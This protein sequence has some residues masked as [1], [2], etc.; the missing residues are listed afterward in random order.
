MSICAR[1]PFWPE[2]F[3]NLALLFWNQILIWFSFSPS[4]SARFLRRS[5]VKYLFSSNSRFS[6]LSWS[7][8]K[9]VLGLF[10]P[11]EPAVEQLPSPTRAFS[12]F[13]IF[14]DRGPGI[15]KNKYL[16][17]QL[18]NPLKSYPTSLADIYGYTKQQRCL[19]AFWWWVYG[20]CHKTISTLFGIMETRPINTLHTS[21]SI[22]PLFSGN[23]L[24]IFPTEQKELSL[25]FLGESTNILQS[26]NGKR[27]EINYNFEPSYVELLFGFS[28]E[29]LWQSL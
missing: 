22:I 17:E 21:V 16:F 12:A 24:W 25:A 29:R 14:R 11:P 18:G 6:R 3:F 5:S 2:F 19:F 23:I 15:D 10:S 28:Q 20:G 4:S 26:S 13:L 27:L 9:A 8:E 7:D 1:S